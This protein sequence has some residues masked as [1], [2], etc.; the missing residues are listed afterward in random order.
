MTPRRLAYVVRIFP[1]ISETFI[2]G[3]MAEL[4]RRGIELRILSL[5]PPQETLQHE[6]ISAAGLDKLT[7]YG[8]ENFDA[9]LRD[10]HPDL[11]HAHFAT[12]S[13]AAAR[14][15]AAATRLPFTFTAHNY[16]IHRKAPADFG[17]RAAAARAVITVSRANADFII[18]TFGVPPEHVHLIPC[19]VDTERFSPAPSPEISDEPPWIVCV[20]RHVKVKNIGLLLDACAELRRRGVEFRARLIGD[21]PCQKELLCAR[22]RLGLDHLVQM[23]GA[24]RQDEVLGWWRR[25]AIGVLPSDSEGMPVCLMEAAACGVAVV[26]TSIPGVTEMVRD[27]TTGLVVPPGNALA[28]AAAMEKLLCDAA[29]RKRFGAAAR[30]HAVENFSVVRQADRLLALWSAILNGGRA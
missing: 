13:A 6:I 5:S 30:Q 29:M 14:E 18:R 15:L 19:G 28:M 20:A 23:P 21:G 9:V 4:R 1:K 17:A 2:A 11:L 7:T 10:F 16:D 22:G 26:A 27:G 25:A 12:E 3:E 8:R 24:G